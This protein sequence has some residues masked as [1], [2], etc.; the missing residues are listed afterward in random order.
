MPWDDCDTP[1]LD[2]R[3]FEEMVAVKVWKNLLTD[4]NTRE[5]VRLVAR[6][7]TAS[8]RAA[9]EAGEHGGGACGREAQAGTTP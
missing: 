5:Q 6:R 2:A 1:S 4:S 9:P 8:P 7:W 3:H